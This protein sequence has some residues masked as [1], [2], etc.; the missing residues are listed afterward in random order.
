MPKLLSRKKFKKFIKS[1]V[2]CYFVLGDNE[3]YKKIQ[4]D[5]YV[6]SDDIYK[7]KAKCLDDLKIA[8]TRIH[9]S[10]L[11]HTI[12][13]IKKHGTD[14]EQSELKGQIG[15]VKQTEVPYVTRML[16]LEMIFGTDTFYK[17]SK[18]IKAMMDSNPSNVTNVEDLKFP[19]VRNF[20]KP[21]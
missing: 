6:G 21:E 18:S 12:K 19:Y 14:Y 20:T 1:E 5:D 9:A 10:H 4:D 15:Y 17:V 3:L 11:Y 7:L 16:V 13:L 2:G 8:Y